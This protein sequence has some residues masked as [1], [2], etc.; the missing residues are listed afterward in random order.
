VRAS[1]STSPSWSSSPTAAASS[2]PTIPPSPSRLRALSTA[3]ASL[4]TALRRRSSSRPSCA[5]LARR[6]RSSAS[7]PSAGAA[8]TTSTRPRCLRR[9]T[10]GR[11]RRWPRRRSQ[12]RKSYPGRRPPP[13]ARITTSERLRVEA[14]TAAGWRVSPLRRPADPAPLD[15]RHTTPG[16]IPPAFVIYCFALALAQL[17]PFDR[18]E[19]SCIARL[20]FARARRHGPRVSPRLT[21]R[22]P[23]AGTIHPAPAPA[24]GSWDVRAMGGRKFRRGRDPETAPGGGAG[25]Q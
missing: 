8:A 6:M 7:A 14:R 20:F 4:A 11:P 24:P 3:P 23:G 10:P 1:A 22:Y 13:R 25:A 16:S 5:P 15:P 18:N 17:S 12:P 19:Y 21:P 9:K 2:P